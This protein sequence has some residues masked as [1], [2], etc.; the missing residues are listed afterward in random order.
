MELPVNG[1]ILI[2]GP[3]RMRGGSMRRILAWVKIWVWHRPV[4]ACTVHM[5]GMRWL[6]L[7][8]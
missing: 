5:D 6:Q 8:Q 3:G 1:V 7:V 2:V 4:R